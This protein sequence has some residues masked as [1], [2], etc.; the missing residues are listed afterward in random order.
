MSELIE[1]EV[2]RRYQNQFSLSPPPNLVWSNL[3]AAFDWMFD[4]QSDFLFV[5]D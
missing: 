5:F 2:S 4:A 1:V 3:E